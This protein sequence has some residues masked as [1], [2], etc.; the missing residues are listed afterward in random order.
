MPAVTITPKSGGGTT[1]FDGCDLAS[2]NNYCLAC[3][4]RP[5]DVEMGFFHASGE[6]G[7]GSK[8]YVYAQRIIE[9]V[10]CYVAASE[11]DCDTL[12]FGHTDDFS[13]QPCSIEL[14]GVRTFPRCFLNAK[15]SKLE[16]PRSSG[17]GSVFARGVLVFT[18]EE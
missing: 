4:P 16:Q 9:V 5:K 14:T 10:I 15:A 18:S 13:G 7:A 2:A 8:N 3:D 1:F 11:S 6:V 17:L 12:F